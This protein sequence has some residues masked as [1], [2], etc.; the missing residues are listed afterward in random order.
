MRDGLY[1]LVN[2]ALPDPVQLGHCCCRCWDA[3]VNICVAATICVR[4]CAQVFEVVCLLE[5]SS[6]RAD[7]LCHLR[8]C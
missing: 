7:I 8:W 3:D 4:C 1:W 2:L 6:I 5:V